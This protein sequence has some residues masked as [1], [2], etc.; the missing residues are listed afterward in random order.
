MKNP[1]H[2]GASKSL[3]LTLTKLLLARGHKVAA[4]SRNVSDIEKQ[5]GKD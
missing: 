1:V 4:T 5:I 2:Y 3:G